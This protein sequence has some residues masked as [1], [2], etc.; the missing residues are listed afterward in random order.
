M[1]VKS[2]ILLITVT[3]GASA[4]DTRATT[5]R[6]PASR[7]PVVADAA[8]NGDAAAVKRLLQQGANVNVAQGDGMTALH[9]AARRGN[10]E[11]ANTL[12]RAKASVTAVTRIG[13]YTPLHV[14]SEVGSAP[15]VAA[16]IKAGADPKA[17]TTTGVTPL[18]LAA[19]S[20]NASAITALVAAGADVI[21][22]GL[23]LSIV[24][25][26]VERHGGRIDASNATDGGAAFD[27][28]LPRS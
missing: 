9:W 21:G 26:I 6:A 5:M 8:M 7:A 17:L 15:V 3:A 28:W 10:V 12:L 24:K 22:T 19:L 27:L 2:A 18:H 1:K 16:L 20:G 25:A 4:Q 13:D 23:G 14:A 11:M